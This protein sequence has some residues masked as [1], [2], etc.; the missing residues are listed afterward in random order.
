MQ[1]KKFTYCIFLLFG[2]ILRDDIS[3][4]SISSNSSL[5]QQNKI[6]I[7]IDVSCDLAQVNQTKMIDTLFLISQRS[8]IQLEKNLIYKMSSRIKF[9]VFDEIESFQRYQN[10]WQS[11]IETS[12]NHPSVF[13]NIYTP[14]FIGTGIPQIEYQIKKGASTQ[15][16]EEYLYGLSYREK[17]DGNQNSPIPPWIT[18]G[19][20]EYFSGGIQV[21]D[22][23]QFIINSKKGY[24]N[25]INYIPEAAQTNFG[26]VIWYMFEKEKGRSFNSAFW[27]LIKFANSFQGSFEYQFGIK[28]KKWLRDKISEIESKYKLES[29]RADVT[30]VS[31]SKLPLY[32]Q[33]LIEIEEQGQNVVYTNIYDNQNQYLYR[34]LA[35]KKMLIYQTST[36]T[37]DN[38]TTFNR[39]EIIHI[40]ENS[41]RKFRGLV[42][43]HF[44]EGQ[45]R[46]SRILASN[47]LQLI[48]VLGKTG[49]YR[50]FKQTQS[51]YSM[52]HESY[53]KTEILHFDE[54]LKKTIPNK[55][56]NLH[57]FDYLLDEQNHQQYFLY[58]SAINN[59]K[60]ISCV[61]KQ[62]LIGVRDT[63]F[64]D[65]SVIGEI[66]L[67]HLIIESDNHLSFVK[68]GENQQQV[69]HLFQIDGKWIVKTLETKGYLY[70]QHLV[71]GSNEIQSSYQSSNA[72]ML[73]K[74]QKDELI[75]AQDTFVRKIFSFDTLKS[76]QTAI[77]N[78]TTYDSSNGY[79]V[80]PFRVLPVK[81]KSNGIKNKLLF[82]VPVKSVFSNSFFT[83]Q[84]KLYFSNEDID[85]AYRTTIPLNL[86]YNSIGTL[87]F[88]HKI[89]SDNKKHQFT[90]SAFSTIDRNR[91]GLSFEHNYQSE[92]SKM[93][94]IYLQFRSRQFKQEY[95]DLF[96]NKVA[97]IGYS[98]ATRNPFFNS[99][100]KYAYQ[101][102][103][104][105]D[106]N[107]SE[108]ATLITNRY[109]HINELIFSISPKKPFQKNG[110]VANGFMNLIVS[111]SKSEDSIKNLSRMTANAKIQ[112]LGKHI[113][114]KSTLNANFSLFNNNMLNVIGGSYGSLISQQYESSLFN[115]IMAKN[116][117][118]MQH[119]GYVRGFFAGSRVGSSSL[120]IQNEVFV[121]PL[122]LFP[123]RVIES[124]FW[125]KL[126][127]VGFLDFGT[128]F[129][130]S[131]PG[132]LS[133]PYNSKIYQANTYTITVNA[134]RDAFLIGLGYGVNF[135]ILGY[136]FR[137]ERAFGF[138]EN[139]IQ[140]KLIHFC[141]GKNF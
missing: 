127:F 9:I 26:C 62:S 135:N 17:L 98:F 139:S 63:I 48:Q 33:Q 13:L 85:L 23:Q 37:N 114:F 71:M 119:N 28:F 1:H 106:L 11:R 49:S 88:K 19:F 50:N 56:E 112:Y 131:N 103:S 102:Q 51:G 16:I 123:S 57:V 92:K 73:N 15:F 32:L 124:N 120:V 14:I 111:S 126:F 116:P 132:D 97:Q 41:S 87:Y 86:L 47:S 75:Y 121:S 79:F 80:S 104:D 54:D 100:V 128:A 24:F 84:S 65:S 72:F 68:S 133:N 61:V 34:S 55:F 96:E 46:I 78:Q 4:Q 109:Y 5:Y 93:H 91:Y 69:V 130:G 94:S 12:L 40:T 89:L 113:E 141:I 101:L 42:M 107:T 44:H 99:S 45:W 52:I 108:N 82:S 66:K 31:L 67:E 76:N 20:I 136:D 27:Y 129:N 125:K 39:F 138:N 43:L 118:F 110:W 122:N 38:K 77:T 134:E 18:K 7:V 105:I 137:I 3:G 140:N 81:I 21:N 36:S 22:F 64:L 115:Q 10:V 30:V 70:Q 2:L 53:G 59:G 58:S 6:E 74:F 29:F 95:G 83:I 117:V 90:S 8:I 25:N 35:N 60:S